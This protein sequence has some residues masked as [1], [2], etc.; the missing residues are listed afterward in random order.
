MTIEAEFGSRGELAKKYTTQGRVQ[1][2]N[3]SV[4]SAQIRADALIMPQPVTFLPAS[5]ASPAVQF[6]QA[7][8]PSPLTATQCPCAKFPW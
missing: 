2:V 3:R 7:M 4:A 8:L 5:V 6:S 1:G